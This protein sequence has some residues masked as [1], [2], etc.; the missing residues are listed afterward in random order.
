MGYKLYYITYEGKSA[1]LDNA[2][3]LLEERKILEILK[4]ENQPLTIYRILLKLKE[5]GIERTWT[6][7]NMKIEDLT[8][9]NRTMIL[10][11]HEIGFAK[12]AADK[13]VFIDKGEIV[14][15]G[16]PKEFFSNPK[17]DRAKSFLSKVLY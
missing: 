12:K 11:T 3:F 6:Y 4:K 16:N 17:T 13:T 8:K 1:D 7:V 2:V 15:E 5:E 9:E 10:V 14:E